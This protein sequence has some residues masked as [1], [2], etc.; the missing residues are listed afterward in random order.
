MCVHVCMHARPPEALLVVCSPVGGLLLKICLQNPLFLQLS[1]KST[2]A[3]NVFTH[4]ALYRLSPLLDQMAEG[5]KKN[6]LLRAIRIF[7]NLYAPLFIYTGCLSSE[8]V[9][10]ALYVDDD[11]EMDKETMAHLR[12]YIQECDEAGRNNIIYC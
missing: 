5:L 6:G 9:Q 11:Y 8:E 12:H 7:P 1:T 3:Q 10:A 2:V 4:E